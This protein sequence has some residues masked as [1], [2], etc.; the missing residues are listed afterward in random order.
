MLDK[1]SKL[2]KETAIYG[3]SNGLNKLLGV[4]LIPIYASYIPITDYGILAIFEVTITFLMSILHLGLIPG[5]QRFFYQEKENNTYGQYLFSIFIALLIFNIFFITFFIIH[6]SIFSNLLIGQKNYKELFI[7]TMYITFTEIMFLLPL[8]ILQFERKPIFYLILNSSKLFIALIFTIYFV[9]YLKISIK[10]IL[11]ARLISNSLITFLAI[12][13]I[14]I[15]KFNCKID[16]KKLYATLKYGLPLIFSSISFLIF[17][18][19]DRY[20]LNWL[21][22]Q[23]ETGKYSFGFKIANTIN[24][25]IIQAIGLSYIPTIYSSEKEVNN[26]RY[27]SKSL[28]YY[29]FTVGLIILVFLYLYE[30]FIKFFVKNSEYIEGFKV[31]PILILNFFVLGMN[32]FLGVGIFLKNKTGLFIIPSTITAF[33][34]IVLNYF[35][36]PCFGMIGAGTATL[37][38]QIIYVFILTIMSNRIYKINF[39]WIKIFMLITL[40]VIAFLITKVIILKSII[41]QYSIK[42]S[43]FLF[44]P[45]ILLKLKFFEEIEIKTI[46]NIFSKFIPEFIIKFLERHGIF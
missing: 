31:V 14:I 34:N 10:G 19:S 24:L 41:I 2:G 36:I 25:L 3:I 26:K 22:T 23:A 28:T 12:I 44:I 43:L 16:I 37:I 39:E 6:A 20:M 11:L 27:Y 33:L 15:P 13:I 46:K 30:D 29:C 40:F 5:H 18:M 7:I 4:I 32:Y 9:V 21:S 17:Q 35:M 42:L 38:S 1:I 8:Q 45:Y